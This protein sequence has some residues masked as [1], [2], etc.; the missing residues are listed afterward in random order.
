MK[1]ESDRILKEVYKEYLYF[2]KNGVHYP[3]RA[4]KSARAE[5]KVGDLRRIL[6]DPTIY[7]LIV[8]KISRK[9]F[10]TIPFTPYVKLAAEPSVLLFLKKYMRFLA[11]LPARIYIHEDIL[12][13]HS[14]RESEVE[15]F[16]IKKIT[17]FLEKV[18]Y[19]DHPVKEKFFRKE[20]ERYSEF[21]MQSL[22]L[23]VEEYEALHGEQ[24]VEVTVPQEIYERVFGAS[25]SEVSRLYYLIPG[26]RASRKERPPAY[27]AMTR[28][29]V[30]RVK[31]FLVYLE[32][33]ES[34]VYL[35]EFYLNKEIEL[36]IKDFTLFRGTMDKI[37]FKLKFPSAPPVELLKEYLYVQVY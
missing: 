22:E 23:E 8:K 24:F 7:V 1:E 25:E 10:E 4:D 14:V 20:N 3:A 9:L 21:T 28:E 15:Q 35:P 33:Q 12:Y 6:V 37:G 29:Q 26:E 36:S 30:F 13:Y 19:P 18:K 16:N 2:L 31:D 17:D 34:F 32:G 11:P 5:V 27:Q